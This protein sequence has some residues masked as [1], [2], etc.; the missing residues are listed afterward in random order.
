VLWEA[1]LDELRW[2]SPDATAARQVADL[3]DRLAYVCSSALVAALGAGSEGI[4]V[5]GPPSQ[6]AGDTADFLVTRTNAGAEDEPV[7]IGGAVIVD[8][9]RDPEPRRAGARPWDFPRSAEGPRPGREPG[10]EDVA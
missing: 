1:L 9:A 8:E 6:P 10:R 3:A 5:S 4:V 2:P 7:I